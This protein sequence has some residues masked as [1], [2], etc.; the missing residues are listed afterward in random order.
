V[1][2]EN[3]GNGL[4]MTGRQAGRQA[5]GQK[6]LLLAAEEAAPTVE[7]QGILVGQ[8]CLGGWLLVVKPDKRVSLQ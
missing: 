2:S 4:M 3:S 5:Q 8:R 6:L 1:D 7:A